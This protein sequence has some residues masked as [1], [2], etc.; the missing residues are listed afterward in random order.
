MAD[1]YLICAAIGGTI[2]IIQLL[3]SFFGLGHH[4][5]AVD[6]HDVTGHGADHETEGSHFLGMLS[7]RAIVAAITFFGL[8]G[9]AA[10]KNGIFGLAA[11]GIALATG[12]AAM[13]AVAAVMRFFNRLQSD[14]T[15]RIEQS[16]GAQGSVYLTVPAEKKGCGK[17]TVAV[18]GRTMEYLAVTAGAA[19]PIGTKIQIVDVIGQDTVEVEAVAAAAVLGGEVGNT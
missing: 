6:S 9:I 7:F 18:Q 16:L 14:G 4:D 12:F 10:N 3:L 17:I 11:I 19:L 5:I 1:I 2:F 15:A 8:A 13:S